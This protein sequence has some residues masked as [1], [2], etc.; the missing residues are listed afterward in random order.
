[1]SIRAYMAL[2]T[3]E[4]PTTRVQPAAI[5]PRPATNWAPPTV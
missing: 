4:Y 3:D 5:A 1:M 2:M